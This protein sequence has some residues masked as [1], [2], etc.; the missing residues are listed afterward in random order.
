[1]GNSASTPATTTPSSCYN[2]RRGMV[3]ILRWCLFSGEYEKLKD[4]FS[5]PV[6][7]AL[8][9]GASLYWTLEHIYLKNYRLMM[10]LYVYLRSLVFAFTPDQWEHLVIRDAVRVL[11]PNGYIEISELDINIRDGGP[12]VTRLSD[13]C[14]YY[15]TDFIQIKI[16]TKLTVNHL[17]LPNY[18]H[19]ETCVL[20]KYRQTYYI[21]F[22]REES[23]AVETER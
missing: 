2:F 9:P 5:A 19:T 20:V 12:C 15:E 4:N 22:L 16:I 17:E 1:M 18:L 3:L 13:A 21:H 10:K 8:R 6:K 11:R 7:D 14:E 23:R